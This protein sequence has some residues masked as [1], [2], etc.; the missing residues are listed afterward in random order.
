MIS[1]T[2]AILAL[3]GRSQE[4]LQ[5]LTWA[6]I[7][8]CVSLLPSFTYFCDEKLTFDAV[9]PK[10]SLGCATIM[11]A[12]LITF[13]A[14]T[15]TTSE[16]RALSVLRVSFTFSQT[17]KKSSEAEVVPRIYR[18]SPCTSFSSSYRSHGWRSKFEDWPS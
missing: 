10:V 7:W 13:Q 4:S 5:T 15:S 2:S 3:I 17:S 16:A 12:F 1:V 18:S 9:S 6:F 14:E 8:T 11:T